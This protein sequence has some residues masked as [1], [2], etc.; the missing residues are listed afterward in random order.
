MDE[1]LQRIDHVGIVVADLD[2]A[3]ATYA[4]LGFRESSRMLLAEQQVEAAFLQSGDS[5]V[6]LIAPTDPAS[7]TARYLQN[8][9]EGVHHICYMV[10]DLPGALATMQAAGLRLIDEQPRRGAH[11]QVAFVHPKAAHGVLIELLAR[12]E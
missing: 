2:A 6:E 3:V 8:R 11:G 5:T 12:Q 1:L 7:G 9:G 4:Q 10:D